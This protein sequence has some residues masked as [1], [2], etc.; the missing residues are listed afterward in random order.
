[1][2]FEIGDK[3]GGYEVIGV[4]GVGGMGKVFKIRNLITDRIEAMKVLLSNLADDPSLADRFVREIKVLASLNHPRIAA[5]YNAL[6]VENHLVMIMEFVQGITLDDLSMLSPIALRDCI[7]YI[8]QVLSGLGYA[9]EKGVI[10]RDIK[11][12]NMMLT[13][14]GFIKI[15]DFGIAKSAA[16]AKL[17]AT[18]TTMGSPYYM[19]PEQVRGIE[20]DARSDLYSVGVSL[21]KLVTGVH[22]FRDDSVYNLMSAHV[23]Q[24]PTP[25]SQ[26]APDIPPAL[27]EIILRALEKDPARRFQTAEEFRSALIGL[28]NEQKTIPV[29]AS[30]E[31]EGTLSQ[32]SMTSP[33]QLATPPV[34]IAS[35]PDNAL[36]LPQPPPPI[37]SR[38]STYAALGAVVVVALIVA[39]AIEFSKFL[40]NRR[41]ERR[42]GSVEGM[43]KEGKEPLPLTLTFPSGDMVLVEGGVAQ[44]GE[45]RHPVRVE[46]FYIDKTEV[47]NGAFLDFCKAIHHTPPLDTALRPVD[48]PVVNVAFDDAQAFCR[49]AGKRLPSGDEWEK[50]A[51]GPDGRLY[52]WGNTLDYERANIPKDKPAA[53]RAILAPA[54]AY[55]AGISPYGALNMLGN[56]WEWVN[57]RDKA[58]EG[59]DFE[60][61]RKTVFPNLNPPLSPTEPYYQT[62]GGSF[63][64]VPDDPTTL[65]WNSMSV[66]ARVGNRQTGFRCARDANP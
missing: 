19:S 31:T 16:D 33:P 42:T 29:A 35:T 62:R 1:M 27:N 57:T 28:L 2:P 48:N 45:D 10:H 40:G 8:C 5:L 21:Y 25:P 43:L 46:S 17:T 44:L 13:T 56:A 6:R 64:F 54:T 61:Y 11:P 58:P 39:S 63:A 15:M 47:T 34:T 4:L 20:V 23:H 22:P 53:H 37:L 14:E 32:P 36:N 66:P 41:Q 51:R 12:G 38:R 7:N 55:P 60:I 18:G 50:A 52:P 30:P 26:V 24:A 65:I 49:W 3:V 9:H 59:L